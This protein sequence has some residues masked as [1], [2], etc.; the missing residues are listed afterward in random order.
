[1][2]TRGAR[3]A[4]AALVAASIAV[5][6][7]PPAQAAPVSDNFNRADS[8]DLGAGWTETG[9]DLAIAGGKLTNPSASNG[10]AQAVA[11]T[12]NRVRATVQAP[13]TGVGYAA[14]ALGVVSGSG[15]MVFVKVQ[16]QNAGGSF[17]R[18]YVGRGNNG[19]QEA[20]TSRAIAPFAAGTLTATLHGSTVYIVMEPL[21]G[22]RIVEVFSLTSVVTGTGVGVGVRGGAELDSF[23]SSDHEQSQPSITAVLSGTEPASSAGWYRTPVTV[24]FTCTPDGTPILSCPSPVVLATD[25]AGQVVGGAVFAEDG[26]NAL[27]S[28]SVDIDRTEP[29]VAVAGLG[30]GPYF[31]SPE[32]LA[33]C[34][35][36][37]ALSGL[38][39]CALRASE[40]PRRRTR[41]VATAVD[42]AGN[43]A[44]TSVVVR[45]PSAGVLGAALQKNRYRVTAGKK[46]T[47]VVLGTKKVFLVGVGDVRLPKAFKQKNGRWELRVRIPAGTPPGK[48]KIT[49]R[50][51]GRTYTLPIVVRRS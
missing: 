32:L 12:G 4:I 42:R 50:D 3:I 34:V 27:T 13:S 20:S 48:A 23:A 49:Y 36:G 25:G 51:R 26:G 30:A 46:Y 8:T 16:S 21:D 22:G 40:L 17:D 44:T 41:V 10:F 28:V 18:V 43:E 11:G 31:E 24:S 15:D 1:M 45:T 5:V 39:S 19:S 35:A 37:D 2:P 6:S 9:T 33:T 29:S 7:A 38:A 47:V 14:L